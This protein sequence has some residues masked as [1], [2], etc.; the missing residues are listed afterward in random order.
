MTEGSTDTPP[1]QPKQF[2][3]TRPEVAEIVYKD[4]KEMHRATFELAGQYGRWL[5][6]SLLLIHGG[7]LFGLFTFLSELADKPDALARYQLTVWWFVIGLM[8]TLFAGLCTWANW[9]LHSDNYDGWANKPMLW[10]PEEW[11]GAT[12]HTWAIDFFYWAALVLGVLASLCIVGGAY[13]TLNGNWVQSVV[14]AVV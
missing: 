12:R 11:A 3:R 4:Y 9:T 5:L 1:L 8:L 2:M 13:S 14:T 10:D 7:A 6:A